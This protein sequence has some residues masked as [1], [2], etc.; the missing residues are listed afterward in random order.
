MP[1]SIGIRCSDLLQTARKKLPPSPVLRAKRLAVRPVGALP[2]SGAAPPPGSAPA[3]ARCRSPPRRSR[4]PGEQAV[5]QHAQPPG[6]HLLRVVKFGQ[7][8]ARFAVHRV[9]N[10]VAVAQPQTER[11]L[12]QPWF[13]LN[14][15]GRHPD[16]FGYQQAAV[17]LSRRLGKIKRQPGAH[18]DR[19]VAVFSMPSRVNEAEVLIL[20]GALSPRRLG[21]A[22]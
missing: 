3:P 19:I 21:E 22:G 13:H 4:G 5:C 10:K 20:V 18:P 16:Q 8:H 1:V 12:D 14:Q 7:E 15:R 11:C 6:D 2:A 17:P 9:G